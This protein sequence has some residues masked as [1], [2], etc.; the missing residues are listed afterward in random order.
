MA[1]RSQQRHKPADAPSPAGTSIETEIAALPDLDLDDLRRR[2]RRLTGR[3][4]PAHW[5]RFLLLHAIAYRLQADAYG[6]LDPSSLEAL[7]RIG[8]ALN[9]SKPTLA[10]LPSIIPPVGPQPTRPGTMLVREW[11]GVLHR[12]MILDRGF[13]W[14]GTTYDSLSSI[15]RLITGTSWSG[16]RFF[17]LRDRGST[18]KQSGGEE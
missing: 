18:D 10:E 17:A 15:A 8:R 3:A 12:V 16:P 1:S 5:S 14:N 7:D 13:A 2:W 11:N 6:D 9:A 4:A